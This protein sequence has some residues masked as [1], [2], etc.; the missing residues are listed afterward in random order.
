MLLTRFEI[1]VFLLAILLLSSFGL[2]ATQVNVARAQTLFDFS[3]SLNGYSISLAPNH[4]GYVEVTVSLVSGTPQNVTLT[5]TVS[6]Q[7]GELSASL[8]QP[9]GYP[10]FVTTLIVTAQNPQPGKQYQIT[11]SGS[12]NGLTHRAPTLTVTIGCAQ[13]TCPPPTATLT[14]AIVGEGTINPSCPAGCSEPVGRTVNVTANPAPSWVFSGWN[15]TGA[16]CANG[17]NANPCAFP[18][19]NASVSITA[20]FLQTQALYTSYA[21]LGQVTPSCPSGCQFPVGSAVS[22]VASPASGWQVAGY[23]LT[24]GVTCGSEVGYVCS[25]AMPSFPVSFQ[26][27]FTEITTTLSITILSTS[28][29]E[30]S[31]TSTVTVASATTSTISTTTVSV[32]VMGTTETSTLFSISS[33][34]VT[35]TQT[36]TS[37]QTLD[38]TTNTT[39]VITALQ[40]PTLELALAGVVLVSL[41]MIVVNLVRRGYRGSVKCSRC[42]FNNASARKYCESCGA[43]LRGN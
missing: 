22:I 36:S 35:Q 1:Q 18:M 3:I 2:L 16:T 9:W 13:G 10:S 38:V 4:S 24:N 23:H 31:S 17:L 43:P 41:A 6:P 37:S 30:S 7:D 15:A 20:N 34:S 12:S 42:G 14:T 28:T 32:I 11:V 33:G 40:N 27:T 19:P 8:A 39:S 29:A 26:V 25:F 21:G 5:S